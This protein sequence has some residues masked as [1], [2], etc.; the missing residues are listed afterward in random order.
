MLRSKYKSR[1]RCKN[2]ENLII[3]DFDDQKIDK[4]TTSMI[5]LYQ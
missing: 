2:K 5:N 3:K 4:I 1:A